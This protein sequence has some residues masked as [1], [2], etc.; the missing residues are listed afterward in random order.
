MADGIATAE[1]ITHLTEFREGFGPPSTFPL[2]AIPTVLRAL[3][4][5]LREF[6][7]T[8]STMTAHPRSFMA[9]NDCVLVFVIDVNMADP[10]TQAR[11]KLARLKSRQVHSN[12]ILT[13]LDYDDPILVLPPNT[14]KPPTVKR[15]KRPRTKSKD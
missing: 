12:I 3:K 8:Y 1:R 5:I 14:M 10:G 13:F 11:T 7:I 6:G 4:K 9:P 15:P 2:P